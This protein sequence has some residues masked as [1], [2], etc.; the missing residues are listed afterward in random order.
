M[1]VLNIIGHPDKKSFNYAIHNK[2]KDHCKKNGIAYKYI[3]LYLDN[4]DAVMHEKES[5]YNKKLIGDYQDLVKW[6]DVI[7]IT[8]PVW[9]SRLTSVLEGF[10]DKILAPGFAYKPNLKKY[11]Y[12]KPLMKNKKVITFLTYEYPEF[13]TKLMFFNSVKWRL[14]FGV[15]SFF[16]VL[17]QYLLHFVIGLN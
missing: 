6:A 13:P 9:W 12:P 2:V 4:F 17:H 16:F 10:F 11:G 1:K 3:D 5:N 15:Y 7:I 8:S 14:L